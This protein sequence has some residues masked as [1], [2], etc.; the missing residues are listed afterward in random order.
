MKNVQK[1]KEKMDEQLRKSVI[2]ER[3]DKEKLSK[4]KP[5][6]FLN[7]KEE[8]GQQRFNKKGQ[9]TILCIEV[10]ITPTE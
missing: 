10:Q 1:E 3:Y 6:S 4:V 9:P 2:G 8:Q 5:P 7:R